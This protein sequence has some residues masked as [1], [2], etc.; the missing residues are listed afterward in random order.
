MSSKPLSNANS[1]NIRN[2]QTKKHTMVHG[3]HQQD[4]NKYTQNFTSSSRYNNP[5]SSSADA[6][7]TTHHQSN[8]ENRANHNFNNQSRV[9]IVVDANGNNVTNK[10][11]A[12][13]N[14]VT[15]KDHY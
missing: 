9:S 3:T 15:P 10:R 14:M 2:N 11:K 7:H 1:Y 4:T 5:S 13:A 8:K 6:T 12:S